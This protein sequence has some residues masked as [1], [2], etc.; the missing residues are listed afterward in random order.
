VELAQSQGLP[1]NEIPQLLHAYANWNHMSKS[2]YQKDPDFV[3]KFNWHING[4]SKVYGILYYTFNKQVRICVPNTPDC[5]SIIK[6][7][8]LDK[9]HTSC[10][11]VGFTKKL[12]GLMNNFYWPKMTKDTRE[13]CKTCATWQQVKNST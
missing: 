10:S 6:N 13:Y 5:N 3:N 7:T 1:T 12:H 11:H 8:F 9:I 4:Y 2:G